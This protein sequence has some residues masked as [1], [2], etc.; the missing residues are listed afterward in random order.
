MAKYDMRVLST[1][2][3]L[4]SALAACSSNRPVDLGEK[5]PKLSKSDLAAYAASWDGYV[6]AYQFEDGS[7]RVRVVL[8]NQGHGSIRVGNRDLIGPPTDP[9][10]NYPAQAT[11]ETSYAQSFWSGFNY[12]ASNARVEN[13]RIRFESSSYELF[14]AYCALQTPYPSPL[15]AGVPLSNCLPYNFL[16]VLNRVD[17][18]CT[19]PANTTNT[20]WTRGDPTVDV[21]CEQLAMCGGVCT[22]TEA[23][24]EIETPTNLSVDAALDDTETK[25]EGTLLLDNQRISIRLKRN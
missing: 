25:L 6:E 17:D 5:N 11:D 9:T 13:E 4:N 14:S 10:A 8:D 23:G 7:D 12:T 16:F 22:C 2:V 15:D 24:C 21:N 20:G 1:L 18:T 19:I 3:L